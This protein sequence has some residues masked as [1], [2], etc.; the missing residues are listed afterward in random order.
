MV[1]RRSWIRSLYL[2]LAALFGLVLLSIGGVRLLDMGLRAWIFTEADSERR[3]Y[4]F[5]PPMPPPTERLERLTGREDL[6]EEERAMVRQ[7]LEEYR[8]WRERSAGI[9]PV[10]A[11]R[12]RTA[13]SSL[14]MILLGLPLYLYHWRLIRAEARRET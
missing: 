8:S 14:A 12:H 6:S 5:Q 2:Y 10:T 13:A 7:W 11:E 3:I 9:D 1:D 4:A